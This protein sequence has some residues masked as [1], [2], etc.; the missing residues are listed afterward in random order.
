MGGG[1]RGAG[2]TTFNCDWLGIINTARNQL[3]QSS[4]DYMQKDKQKKRLSTIHRVVWSEKDA[5]GPKEGC[6]RVGRALPEG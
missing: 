1:A 4:L 6:Q 3:S 2:A 5:E